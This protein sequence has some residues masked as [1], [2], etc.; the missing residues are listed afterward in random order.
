MEGARLTWKVD[1]GID[2]SMDPREAIMN[3][4]AAF[5]D[6]DY[7]SCQQHIED[8]RSWLENGGFAP[9][10]EIGS[11]TRL[12]RV[13]LEDATSRAVCLGICESIESVITKLAPRP[14]V[15]NDLRL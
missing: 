3:L 7:E 9:Q 2:A 4:L 5:E 1:W 6:R 12:G 14:S 11:P 8:L 10:L 15:D 13:Q